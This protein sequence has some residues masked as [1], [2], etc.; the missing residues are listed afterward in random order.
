MHFILST[1][2][3]Y[4]DETSCVKCQIITLLERFHDWCGRFYDTDA[5]TLL[6]LDVLA[7]TINMEKP[8][9]PYTDS[10]Q[11]LAAALTIGKEEVLWYYYGSL[12]CADR[13]KERRK[14]KT[15]G[16]GAKQVTA[17]TFQ[18]RASE[19][20]ARVTDKEHIEHNDR[21]VPEPFRIMRYSYDCR[22]FPEDTTLE[23]ESV[24]KPRE[25][26]CSFSR[27]GLH[28]PYR[29]TVFIGFVVFTCYVR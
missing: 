5:G 12:L 25:N 13:P 6:V 17:K 20:C 8:Y 19:L 23:I 2:E 28:H 16:D 18:K 11:R 15:H 4:N 26:N 21:I 29:T 27:V 10:S 9:I 24:N 1:R 14:K 7:E 3:V 22:Y